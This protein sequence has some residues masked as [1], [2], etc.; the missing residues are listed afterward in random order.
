[1]TTPRRLRPGEIAF[2][3]VALWIAATVHGPAGDI[4][5]AALAPGGAGPFLAVLAALVWLA[6]GAML[7]GAL[8]SLVWL[9]VATIRTR[10][11]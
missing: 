3:L 7:A 2:A 4:L 11:R 5:A 1:M 6:S 8:L 9:V 10:R